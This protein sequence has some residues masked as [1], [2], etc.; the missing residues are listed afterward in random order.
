MFN[1]QR[2]YLHTRT[3]LECVMKQ[4]HLTTFSPNPMGIKEWINRGGFIFKKII[5][6]FVLIIML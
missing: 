6:I 1:L 3:I 5:F 2:K 4:K